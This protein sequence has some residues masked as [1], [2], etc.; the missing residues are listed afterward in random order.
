ME[1]SLNIWLSALLPNGPLYTHS[2]MVHNRMDTLFLLIRA[3][4]NDIKSASEQAD[5]ILLWYNIMEKSL[6]LWLPALLPDGLLYTHF[7]T[8]EWYVTGRTCCSQSLERGYVSP[9]CRNHIRSSAL[10][11]N[12]LASSNVPSHISFV[13]KVKLFLLILGLRESFRSLD[14]STQKH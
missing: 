11:P 13:E 7:L 12:D 9:P 2:W 10:T 3:R 14:N 1:K 8:P 6:N 5:N 4:F